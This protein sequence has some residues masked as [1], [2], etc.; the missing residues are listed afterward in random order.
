MRRRSTQTARSPA[1]VNG[2]GMRG[3]AANGNDRRKTCWQKD[4]VY[5]HFPSR[6]VSD[7]LFC[8]FV[9][10]DRAGRQVAAKLP[11]HH[12]WKLVLAR[13][14]SP[15]SRF[16]KLCLLRFVQGSCQVKTVN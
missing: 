3:V 4:R 9:A 8:I 5:R 14:S 1:S 6:S 13:E 16:G 2:M 12:H 15:P 11:T 10:G 7:K